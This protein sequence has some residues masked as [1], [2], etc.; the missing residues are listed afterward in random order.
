MGPYLFFLYDWDN[1][2]SLSLDTMGHMLRFI[3]TSHETTCNNSHEKEM[4]YQD[5]QHIIHGTN[6]KKRDRLTLAKWVSWCNSHVNVFTAFRQIQISARMSIMTNA[7]WL[8]QV[9]AYTTTYYHHT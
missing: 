8:Q 3:E 7:F 6:I 5:I 2:G 4:I 1:K 9:V